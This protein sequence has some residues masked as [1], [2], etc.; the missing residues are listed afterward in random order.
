MSSQLEQ[1]GLEKELTP[2]NYRAVRFG[3]LF[4][5]ATQIVPYVVLY[6]AKYVYAGSYVSPRASQI[7]G[8]VTA[9][10]MLVSLVVAWGV[11]RLSRES[12]D[13]QAIRSRLKVAAVLG[14]FAIL[15][16]FYQWSGRYTSPQSRFGEMFFAITGA[17]IVY[18]VV[19]L[20]M[21]WAAISRAGRI[22]LKPEKYWTVEAGVYF[23]GFVA[24]AWIASWIV[25]YLL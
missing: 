7:L 2:R 18:A 3:F 4:F 15:T 6:E 22:N 5:V 11:M 13:Q 25:V 21:L 12:G 10:L 16:T 1:L 20:I 9:A 17:D 8:V 14:I 19:G 24:L 23:W